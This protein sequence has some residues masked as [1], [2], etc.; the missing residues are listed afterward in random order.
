MARLSLITF[1]TTLLLFTVLSEPVPA[2]IELRVSNPVP[3][4]LTMRSSV[5]NGKA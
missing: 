5:Y 2:L 3:G 4:L 1:T